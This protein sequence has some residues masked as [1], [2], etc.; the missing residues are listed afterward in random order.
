MSFSNIKLPAGIG[1]F[2]RNGVMVLC[3][4][5]LFVWLVGWLVVFAC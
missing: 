1:L 3:P 4:N 5:W 2:Q